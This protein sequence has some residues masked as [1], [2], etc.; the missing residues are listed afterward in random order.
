MA[1]RLKSSDNTFGNVLENFEG[2]NTN[3]NHIT[4]V[5][6]FKKQ[7]LDM[8][9]FISIKLHLKFDHFKLI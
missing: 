2:F 6:F 3:E 1:F 7:E 9:E 8:L 4:K 5:S